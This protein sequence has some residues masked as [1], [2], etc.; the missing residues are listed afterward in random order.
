MSGVQ[1]GFVTEHYE[2]GNEC[3]TLVLGD[4]SVGVHEVEYGDGVACIGF[5][6][7]WSG[8]IGRDMVECGYM[9][10]DE[11]ATELG[12]KFI[13]KFYKPESIDVV[14]HRLQQLKSDKFGA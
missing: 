10:G 4:G 8:E 6:D 3:E 9:T 13:M 7:G 14:I 2:D 1:Y 5:S 12:C 11:L